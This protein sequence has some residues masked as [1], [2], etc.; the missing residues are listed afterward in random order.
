MRITASKQITTILPP[1]DCIWMLVLTEPIIVRHCE[2]PYL[3][4]AV[5]HT[6]SSSTLLQ[7]LHNGGICR[8]LGFSV[9]GQC[10]NQP[11]KVPALQLCPSFT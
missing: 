4:I 9:V 1:T 11:P 8:R 3:F 6:Y 2:I 7:T 10:G 5:H